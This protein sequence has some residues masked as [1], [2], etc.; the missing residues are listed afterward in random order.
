MLDYKTLEAFTNVVEQGSFERAADY[1][2]LTQ[3]AVSQRVKLLES[4]LGK[5]VLIRGAELLTTEVGQALLNHVSKVR[6]LEEQL[7]TTVALPDAEAV[8]I[9]LAVN[10]DSLSCWWFPAV[11]DYLGRQN[12]MLDIVIEDQNY[13]LERMKKGDVSA[14]L[15]T[16]PKPLQGARCAFV[17]DL[18]CALYASP[19]FT[20]RYFPQ[21]LTAE[22]VA[23]A[24]AVIYGYKD[25]LHDVV[26][27]D[28]AIKARY[29]FHVCPSSDGIEQMINAGMA[30]GI[31]AS[32]QAQRSVDSGKCIRLTEIADT[33]S[34]NIPL[35]WHYWRQGTELFEKLIT[36]MQKGLE[37]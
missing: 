19:S 13:G 18:E 34:L 2:G 8:R 29:P 36:L 5:P 25:E 31:L 28:L 16:S 9:R 22:A 21:G 20:A 32:K 3:S 15:C 33:P 35:Y 4:R 27:K 10:A 1:M 14:C 11:A 6:L 23:K 7:S 37:K 30:Y 26:M 24:P 17:G 12:L